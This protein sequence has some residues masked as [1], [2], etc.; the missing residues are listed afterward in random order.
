MLEAEDLATLRV[1]AGHD[2][3]DGAVLAGG[4][5]GLEDHQQRVAVLGVEPGL[6]LG[7][8]FDVIRRAAIGS[9]PSSCRTV[10]RAF[11]TS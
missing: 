10:W 7:E 2:V 3:L 6:E 5:H 11:A 1:D 4:V 9:V 8:P